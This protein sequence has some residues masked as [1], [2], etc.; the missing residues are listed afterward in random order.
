M[1]FHAPALVAMVTVA[2]VWLAG[3]SVPIAPVRTSAAAQVMAPAASAPSAIVAA[4]PPAAPAAPPPAPPIM[5]FDE[6]VLF[7]ANNLFKSANLEAAIS[8][9]SIARLP[10]VID[11]LVDGVSGLQSAAT[12]TMERRIGELVRSQYP[13]FELQPFN[14][15]TLA[16][17]PL[18]FI[19]TL[20]AVNMD[21]SNKPG[22]DW[23]RVCLALLDLRSGKIVSKGFARAAM[24]GVDLTPTAFFLDT[25]AWAPDPAVTGYITTCQGTRA[26]DPIK[27]AYYDRIMA[28]VMINDAVVAYNKGDYE[29]AF[30]LYKGLLRQPGGDQLRVY[31]GLY[32]AA[33]RLNRK[34]E[35][36]QAFA[37]IVEHGLAQRQLGVKFLFRPGSTLFTPDP[38]ISGAYPMWLGQLSQ[39]ASARTA[40]LEVAGHT[41]RTGPEPLNERLSL[42]RAQYIKQRLDAVA[43]ALAQRTSASGMGSSQNLS[44]LGTDDMR[45]AL[46]RRVEFKVKDC[47]ASPDPVSVH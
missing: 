14:G 45:D 43:P 40:C 29:E 28:A 2:T 1:S 17:G 33:S 47:P 18:L 22:R 31:Q 19:G 26:G 6:A 3:C 11:P 35:A 46:D 15:A 32:L 27:P 34:E 4:P 42:M 23:H 37:R 13:N 12:E 16:R 21:G 24:E 39:R 41:S 10:L 9:R 20:T 30:D 5:P 25:P 38:L 7:A 36:Q 8:S 44:G